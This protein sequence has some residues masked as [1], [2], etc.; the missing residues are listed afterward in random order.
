MPKKLTQE[1]IIKKFKKIHG[2]KY[3]YS[4]SVYTGGKNKLK[5]IC[6]H[7]SHGY[8]EFEQNP[9]GHFASKNPCPKCASFHKKT[10][11]LSTEKD[12]LTDFIKVHGEK[13][14]YSKVKYTHSKS[15]VTIICRDDSHG[16]FEFEQTPNSHGC[17]GRGCPKCSKCY[18]VNEKEVIEKFKK[19]HGCRYDYSKVSYVNSYKKV[20]IICKSHGEFKLSP[21]TH[22]SGVK[23]RFC[24]FEDRSIKYRLDNDF[25]IKK[26]EKV[27]GKKYDYSE[28]VYIDAKKL[29]VLRCKKHGKFKIM[30]GLHL[31]G[32]GCQKCSKEKQSSDRKINISTFKEKSNL[33]HCGKYDYCLVSEIGFELSNYINIVCPTHGEFIQLAKFHMHGQGCSECNSSK[34]EGRVSRCLEQENIKYIPQHKFDDCT[35]P[36]TKRR[37]MFDF[38]LPE[39]NICI[40]FDGGQHFKPVDY[41]GGQKAFDKLIELDEI[42]NKYCETK[43]IKLIRIHYKTKNLKKYIKT[44]IYEY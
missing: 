23:C 4:K 43:N 5:I 30:Y 6:N 28:L 8:F 33:I 26:L 44:Q 17:H 39:Y 40:E 22:L 12:V 20:T 15:K 32:R 2:E 1:G 14:D 37:L 13:Y 29:I 16:Y 42:K 11:N 21:H 27:H 34:G 41:F 38:Y 36:K 31:A 18:R 24:A 19:I 3:D 35:N 7:E 10:T 9:N 25:Y